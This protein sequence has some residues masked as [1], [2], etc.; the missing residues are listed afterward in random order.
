MAY[1]KA[2]ATAC[3]TGDSHESVVDL[4]SMWHEV[5]TDSTEPVSDVGIADVVDAVE[6]YSKAMDHVSSCPDGELYKKVD[7][8]VDDKGGNGVA[9]ID[10]ANADVNSDDE[11]FS[12]VSTTMLNADQRNLLQSYMKTIAAD[13][14]DVPPSSQDILQC[15]DSVT[16]DG[17]LVSIVHS[18]NDGDRISRSSR[19]RDKRARNKDYPLTTEKATIENGKR[20]TPKEKLKRPHNTVTRST[21]STKYE[22]EGPKTVPN[23]ESTTPEYFLNAELPQSAKHSAELSMCN[24]GNDPVCKSVSS[25]IATGDATS[26]PPRKGRKIVSKPTAA[27][28]K[29]L[30]QPL[31]TAESQSES[32]FS[33]ELPAEVASS[34]SPVRASSKKAKSSASK[35]GS[36]LK[37][38]ETASG[39]TAPSKP[40][41]AARKSS[42]HAHKVSKGKLRGNAVVRTADTTTKNAKKPAKDAV[43][44]EKSGNKQTDGEMCMMVPDVVDRVVTEPAA[45]GKKRRSQPTSDIDVSDQ[46]APLKKAKHSSKNSALKKSATLSAEGASSVSETVP[47]SRK[48]AT[49]TTKR[50]VAS[51][52]RLRAAGEKVQKME[53]AKSLPEAVKLYKRS[54]PD[55]NLLL[56]LVIES[57]VLDQ[58]KRAKFLK[59]ISSRNIDFAVLSDVS[60]NGPNTKRMP[61][62]QAFRGFQS[63]LKAVLSD[64]NILTNSHTRLSKSTIVTLI[65]KILPLKKAADKS[66][67]ANMRSASVELETEALNFL[68]TFILQS[69]TYIVINF[70][71]YNRRVDPHD[72][73]LHCANMWMMNPLFKDLLAEVTHEENRTIYQN[74]PSEERLKTIIMHLVFYLTFDENSVL[75]KK[76]NVEIP[77]C[78]TLNDVA[79]LLNDGF[80][81]VVNLYKHSSPKSTM[82]ELR[83]ILA[84][85]I[86]N[87]AGILY[88]ASNDAKYR[89]NVHGP[90]ELSVEELEML[91]RDSSLA[92]I[93]PTEM[94]SALQT[95]I[96]GSNKILQYE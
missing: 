88:E 75:R 77:P 60:E 24:Q 42:K 31:P 35:M 39:K 11:I 93:F 76:T 96:Q 82:T 72:V 89:F 33:R 83:K 20:N 45:K 62:L 49:S 79:A 18:L 16:S 40:G 15:T 68:T 22:N 36:T 19:K 91:L 12:Q 50:A 69:F 4:Y 3:E 13:S 38:A 5:F 56:Q 51:I 87:V 59:S 80:V 90:W 64:R 28:W 7:D 61:E 95:I 9:T 25:E 17:S 73:L 8:T 70:N 57:V 92:F 21:V 81:P 1:E 86:S 41:E 67:N 10:G 48:T 2:V 29:I 84:I 54:L 71:L 30:N 32:T 63:R 66:D 74:T 47:K 44:V 55:T 65:N 14:V 6:D 27:V 85:I 94:T 58:K 53:R 78:A 26:N 23:I 37:K 43:S 34:T 46:G 52:K